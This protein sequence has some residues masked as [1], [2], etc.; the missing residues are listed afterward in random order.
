MAVTKAVVVH[1]A[2]LRD[3]GDGGVVGDVL[4][5]GVVT[6]L[7]PE[8]HEAAVLGGDAAVLAFGARRRVVLDGGC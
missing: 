3:G 1:A 2:V 8:R 7:S 6:W 5:A 4:E